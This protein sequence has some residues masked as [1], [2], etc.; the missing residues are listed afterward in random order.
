MQM[1]KA[2][3]F[4]VVGQVSFRKIIS[5]LYDAARTIL[6]TELLPFAAPPN[7]LRILLLCLYNLISFSFRTFVL[8]NKKLTFV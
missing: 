3:Q 6:V 1:N 2:N 5:F 4:V 7:I 8:K